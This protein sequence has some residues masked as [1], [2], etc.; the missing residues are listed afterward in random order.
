MTSGVGVNLWNCHKENAPPFC[1]LH[2]FELGRDHLGCGEGFPCPVLTPQRHNSVL[3]SRGWSLSAASSALEGSDEEL[4]IGRKTS[5]FTR[6]YSSPLEFFHLLS[7]V[8]LMVCYLPSAIHQSLSVWGM[9]FT[10]FLT[11]P[12]CCGHSAGHSWRCCP[13]AGMLRPR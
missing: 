5:P 13:A 6:N 12:R 1:S 11:S 7:G 3:P 2:W 10:Y 8:T 9:T 4:V